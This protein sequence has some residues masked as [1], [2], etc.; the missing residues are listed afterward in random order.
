MWYNNYISFLPIFVMRKKQARI[1]EPML[2]TIKPSHGNQYGPT[3]E[4]ILVLSYK[5]CK[6]ISVHLKIRNRSFK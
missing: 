2:A 1:Y 6:L 4:E 5:Y 3:S